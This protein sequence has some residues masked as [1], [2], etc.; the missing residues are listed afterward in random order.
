MELKAAVLE[1]VSATMPAFSFDADQGDWLS[2]RNVQAYLNHYQ[3]NFSKSLDRIEHRFGR[4]EVGGYKV[5]MHYWLPELARG[6]VFLIHGYFDHAGVYHHIIRFLLQNQFAVVI[7]DLPGHGLSSGQLA[8]IDSFDEYREAFAQC[9]QL[10]RP[11]VPGP[12]HIVAQSTGAAVAINYLHSRGAEAFKHIVLLAPLVRSYGWAYSRW[13]YEVLKYFCKRIPRTFA[14][15]SHS[16]EFID[17][18]RRHDPLQAR[19]LPLRWVGANKR[20]IRTVRRYKRSDCAFLVIQ[21]DDDTTVDW[22][23]NTRLIKKKFPNSRLQI[24]PGARHQLV[25]ESGEYRIK[26]FQKLLQYLSR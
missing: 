12:H 23:Y 7:C 4:V 24:I 25:N 13:A 6:T 16:P 2:G 17:F 11:Q 18:L 22:R 19:H 8:S 26:V 5:A 20:W 9:L 3:I 1:R 14:I 21:G 10:C 15:N